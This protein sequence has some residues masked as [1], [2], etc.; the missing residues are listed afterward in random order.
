[1]NG[2]K[3]HS[4][5]KESSRYL[6]KIKVCEEKQSEARSCRM[7][8]HPGAARLRI[9]ASNWG[10][11]GDHGRLTERPLPGAVSVPLFT[12]HGTQKELQPLHGPGVHCVT[13]NPASGS[14]TGGHM[15]AISPAGE[16]PWAG[17]PTC[18]GQERVLSSLVV[19]QGRGGAPGPQRGQK[20]V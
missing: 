2:N 16:L 3:G 4:K 19:R 14:A 15:P 20:W 6:E 7:E 11:T 9:R 12:H 17:F 1:M 13:K 10:T 5:S 18:T 8:L